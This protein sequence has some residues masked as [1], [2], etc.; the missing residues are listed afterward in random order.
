MR[1]RPRR[2]RW[3][4]GRRGSTLRRRRWAPSSSG[5]ALGHGSPG[6]SDGSLRRIPQGSPEGKRKRPA[7]LRRTGTIPEDHED[8]PR[9]D[10]ATFGQI[11]AVGLRNE[12]VNDVASDRA[13]HVVKRNRRTA[14]NRMTNNMTPRARSTTSRN[15]SSL[16]RPWQRGVSFDTLRRGALTASPAAER[17]LGRARRPRSGATIGA[18]PDVRR[19]TCSPPR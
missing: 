11:R 18:P 9:P 4:R 13:R 19:R 8:A 1:W 6:E 17:N 7:L 5:G 10:D 3:L 16:G 12:P 2:S 15:R 14:A